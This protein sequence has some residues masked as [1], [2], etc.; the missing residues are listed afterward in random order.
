MGIATIK[1]DLQANYNIS[2]PKK[3]VASLGKEINY[4]CL[5]SN[6]RSSVN[7]ERQ[8]HSLCR[9]CTHGKFMDL[10]ST[11]MK[12]KANSRLRELAPTVSGGI[13]ET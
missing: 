8:V 13:H 12:E 5:G 11:V 4:L 1:A 6:V 10:A 2:V 9:V 7:R 3:S